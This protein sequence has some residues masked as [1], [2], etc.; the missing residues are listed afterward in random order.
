MGMAS[1]KVLLLLAKLCCGNWRIHTSIAFSSDG[2]NSSFRCTKGFLIQRLQR[3]RSSESLLVPAQNSLD[4]FQQLIE[5]KIGDRQTAS[6][7]QV[8]GHSYNI[9]KSRHS[10]YFL[11]TKE[12]QKVSVF[13]IC[14]K[15]I[16]HLFDVTC[17][18][19][20]LYSK[21]QEYTNQTSHDIGAL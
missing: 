4:H 1:S 21:S 3:S 13:S 15:T 7:P 6:Q 14:T 17:Y 5:A 18:C 9:H 19:H 2:A 10:G 20:L 16:G 11:R 12:S 8:V